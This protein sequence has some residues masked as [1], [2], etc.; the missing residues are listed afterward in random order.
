MKLFFS[1]SGPA[2]RW[3]GV[4][5]LWWA[6]FLSGLA[7][8][9]ASPTASPAYDY[10]D[11]KLITGVLYAIGSDQKKIL[12]TFRRTAM[13]SGAGVHVE[14]QF[15]DINGTVAAVEKIFYESNQLV[16]Y[17]MQDFQAQVSGAIL[18]EPD[19]KKPAQPQIFINYARGLNPSKGRGRPLEP[20]TVI[21]DTLYPFM[22]DH[23][24][25]L[26]LSKA[27]RFRFISLEHERTFEFSLLKTGEAVQAGQPV[28]QITMK[29][30]SLFVAAEVKPIVFVVQKNGPHRMLS[31]IGRTTPRIRTDKSWKYL[32]AE[33]IFNSP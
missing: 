32:D 16:S 3:I 10:A 33:T 31:Y 18:I 27:V 15:L 26:M 5:A 29:P 30:V 20:D 22:M 24:G 23:W 11:P 6:G 17:E 1:S 7:V 2:V 13:R 8:A 25:D 14:R 12:F 21:D 19:P 9:A 4:L 28:V